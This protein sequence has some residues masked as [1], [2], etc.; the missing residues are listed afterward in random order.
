M[1]SLRLLLALCVVEA[2]VVKFEPKSGWFLYGGTAVQAF[3]ILSGFYM[4]LVLNGH[5]RDRP[6]L[7]FW[8]SRYLRLYPAYFIFALAELAFQFEDKLRFLIEKAPWD[9][10]LFFALSNLTLFGKDLALF[11]E[12]PW[13]QG[14]HLQFTA[15]FYRAE[16]PP[17]YEFIVVPPSWTISMELAFYLI[18]PFFLRDLKKTACLFLAAL[19]LR[20]SLAQ[21]GY[22][23]DPWNY[24]FLP[25]ELA[26]FGIGALAYFAYRE[27]DWNAR[28]DLYRKIGLA[29]GALLL[30]LAIL[31]RPYLP[32]AFVKAV[33]YDVPAIGIE[34]IPFLLLTVLIAPFLFFT[35]RRSRFDREM[36]DWSY[37][38]YIGHFFVIVALKDHLHG[39]WLRAAVVGALALLSAVM[40][41]ALEHPVSH[42]RARWFGARG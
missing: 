38:F 36:G 8:A 14:G 31:P 29:G 40:V 26:L 11:L 35:S 37:I 7:D 15:L 9:T 10:W 41:R 39:L 27:V 13:S 30:F 25:S 20:F 22:Y 4:A 32:P 12:A 23:A 1:G 21:A 33:E 2:H 5:Y 24:R 19:A 18:A 16:N 3:F 34:N 17:L 6:K 28:P 42:L